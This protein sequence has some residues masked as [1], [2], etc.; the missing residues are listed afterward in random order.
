MGSWD[1]DKGPARPARG[2]ARGK[3]ERPMRAGRVRRGHGVEGGRLFHTA[4]RSLTGRLLAGPATRSF[5]SSGDTIL[6]DTDHED[7]LDSAAADSQYPF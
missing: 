3:R 2:P 4:T 6:T 7:I 5:C 1:G